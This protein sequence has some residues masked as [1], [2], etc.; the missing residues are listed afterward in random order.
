MAILAKESNLS[1]PYKYIRHWT[2][3]LSH[4]PAYVSADA[5]EHM[6]YTE[7]LP[8]Q[9]QISQGENAFIAVLSRR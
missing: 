2:E 5:S 1:L 6:W 9:A 3:C 8:R 7:M 4:I